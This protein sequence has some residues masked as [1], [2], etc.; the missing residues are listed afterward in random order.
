MGKTRTIIDPATKEE[1]LNSLRNRVSLNEIRNRTG[2][3]V[4]ILKRIQ[5]ESGI[6]YIPIN[7]RFRDKD[8]YTDYREVFVEHSKKST[9]FVKRLIKKYDIIPHDKCWWCGLSEWIHGN[10]VL[11]LDHINGT[12]RD[13]R[14]ENLRFLCPNCHS[15]T[16]TF[17]GRG[18]NGRLKVT[19]EKLMA[20]LRET[21]NV[22]QAL[23]LVNLTPKGDN[24][25]RAQ[26]LLDSK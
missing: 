13:H 16:P 11:E 12:S 4:L 10:L 15:Q 25:K 7:S 6:E 2:Y 8:I 24:Y 19:D 22:H 26:K 20:A 9:E 3:G 23:L 1:I 21:K 5:Q 17:R 14:I 18:I